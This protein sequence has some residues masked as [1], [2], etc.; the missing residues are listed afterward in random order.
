[1]KKIATITFH[2]ALNYGAVLQTY[3]LQSV[4]EKLG[5][6]VE[7]IDYRSSY[8]EKHYSERFFYKI[9]SVK[10]IASIF[11]YNSYSIAKREMFESF[12]SENIH[13][14]ISVLIE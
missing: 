5:A 6:E 2:R 14:S 13:L 12:V 1:M 11:L 9:N 7:V 10:K 3:A 4:L 8:L